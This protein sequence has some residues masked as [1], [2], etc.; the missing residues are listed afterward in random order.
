MLLQ[1]VLLRAAAAAAFLDSSPDAVSE[2]LAAHGVAADAAGGAAGSF[3]AS[4]NILL[5]VWWTSLFCLDALAVAAQ[6]LVASALNEAPAAPA[7]AGTDRGEPARG[8]LARA[9]AVCDRLFAYG[10]VSG[11][12]V[13][14]ALLPST[15]AIARTFSQD[16]VVVEMASSAMLLVAVLQP[17]NGL[18]F[19][20]D[21]VFQGALDFSY[22]AV[23]MAFASAAALFVL[24]GVTAAAPHGAA[25]AAALTPFETIWAAFA[26]LQVGRAAGI[27]WRYL[28]PLGLGPL[29]APR[30]AAGAR[31]GAGEEE[32]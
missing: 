11:V 17:L 5:Q 9:R 12:A 15:G 14:L 28:N 29:R 24:G 19:V 1:A 22:L 13:M 32:E 20:G 21:G 27:F 10:L 2:M 6:G 16:A 26:V 30:G 8:N 4:H 31:A 3:S 7:G 18:V 25:A 23:S